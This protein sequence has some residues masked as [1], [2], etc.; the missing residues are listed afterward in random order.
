[1]FIEIQCTHIRPFSIQINLI[2]QTNEVVKNLSNKM[3]K[4]I[5]S[6]RKSLED[7]RYLLDSLRAKIQ[8]LMKM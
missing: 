8:L 3:S 6:N 2:S 7:F 4:Q 5:L 1:M